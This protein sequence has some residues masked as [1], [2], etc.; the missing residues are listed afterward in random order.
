MSSRSRNNSVRQ[1]RSED[2]R[3]ITGPG[4][5]DHVADAARGGEYNQCSICKSEG[6]G[7]RRAYQRFTMASSG[8]GMR[9]KHCSEHMP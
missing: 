8:P 5:H 7:T 9:I 6:A 4:R 1:Q 3:V 2:S